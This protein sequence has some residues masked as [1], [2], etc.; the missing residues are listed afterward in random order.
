MHLNGVIGRASVRRWHLSEDL[1][2]VQEG[3]MQ[4]SK[5]GLPRGK[6][7]CKGPEAEGFLDRF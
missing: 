7:Q 6:S 5:E 2:E 1:K 4:I 3:A